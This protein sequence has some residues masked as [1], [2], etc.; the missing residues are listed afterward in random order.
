MHKFLL[1]S[2]L[3]LSALTAGAQRTRKVKV[4][5]EFGTMVI[6][7]YNQTP[8][9][10]DNFIKL[11]KAHFYDSLLFHRVI[12]QFMIQGG[13]PDSKRAQPG[14]ALGE[15]SVGYLIP[16]EF[17]LDLFHKKGALAAARDDNPA[18]SSDGSQFYIVQGKRFT[19][20]QLDTLERTRL[21][22][23]K[24]PVDQ[25]EVYKSI[26]GSPQLDQNYTVFGEV[27]EGLAVIDSIAAQPV[28]QRK[29]PLRDIRMKIRLQRRFLF[30]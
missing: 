4:E 20:G 12:Q 28:D 8:K 21:G 18:K 26:G 2:L 5:T 30:F 6:R 14:A 16:A 27:I 13:D 24:I 1:A 7:L 23:R 9:H 17:Q 3:L 22:G 11:V 29:R 10:R 19:D 25:R 15:G